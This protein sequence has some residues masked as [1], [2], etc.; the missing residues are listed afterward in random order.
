MSRDTH[1]R[2]GTLVFVAE[3]WRYPVKSM[4]GERLEH[5]NIGVDGIDGDRTVHVENGH[6][7]LA[8]ARK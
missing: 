8:T 2:N 6:G 3:I 7:R 4:G 5:V 1:P